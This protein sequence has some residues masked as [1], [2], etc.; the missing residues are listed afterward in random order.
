MLNLIKRPTI[1]PYS[2]YRYLKKFTRCQ[3]S[4][5]FCSWAP[6]LSFHFPP[7]IYSRLSSSL[8]T[9]VMFT[10]PQVMEC[11][12][13]CLEWF[14][15]GSISVLPLLL[16]AKEVQ[17]FPGLGIYSGIFAIYFTYSLNDKSRDRMSLANAVFSILCLLYI[18]CAMNVV[19]DLLNM[20]LGV[21]N[22]F[23]CKIIIF[24]ISCA[25]T[26]STSRSNWLTAD[27]RS[28]YNCP[29]HSKCF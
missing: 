29:G 10:V 18:F 4:N 27:A 14:L 22:K 21:S 25:D 3:W 8:R 12:S 24:I 9:A 13:M 28:Q 11:F 16:F 26:S 23:I 1:L 5:I 15:F 6:H 19:C 17:L 2:T 20:I 7:L